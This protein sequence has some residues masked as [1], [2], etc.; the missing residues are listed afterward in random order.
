MN[1]VA[2]LDPS[3]CPVLFTYSYEVLIVREIQRQHG[4]R[5]NMINLIDKS[6]SKQTEVVLG[7]RKTAYLEKFGNL[8]TSVTEFTRVKTFSKIDIS[9]EFSDKFCVILMQDF[10]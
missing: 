10:S 7:F 4:L 9:T 2:L 5:L 1:C 3:F 8:P 6:N